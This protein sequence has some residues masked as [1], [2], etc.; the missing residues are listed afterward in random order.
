[1]YS[2][3][4]QKCLPKDIEDVNEKI[5]ADHVE[6]WIGAKYMDSSINEVRACI[7]HLFSSC[8]TEDLVESLTSLHSEN[9]TLVSIPEEVIKYVVSVIHS[10]SNRSTFNQMEVESYIKNKCDAFASD[11]LSK[12]VKRSKSL[13]SWG[14]ER[15]K[16]AAVQFAFEKRYKFVEYT[17]GRPTYQKNFGPATSMLLAAVFRFTWHLETCSKIAFEAPRMDE[18]ENASVVLLDQFPMLKER[19]QKF[20]N[21]L[22]ADFIDESEYKIMLRSCFYEFSALLDI[23]EKRYSTFNHFEKFIE[24]LVIESLLDKCLYLRFEYS[25]ENIERA[26]NDMATYGYGKNQNVIDLEVDRLPNFLMLNIFAK[27]TLT[28]PFQRGF[29][30]LALIWSE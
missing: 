22:N 30:S 10:W 17:P 24:D 27:G 19:L 20:R 8:S 6:A 3:L 23:V 18:L 21:V 16:F 14:N 11:I 9:G 26:F 4:K 29:E 2:F 1:M 7:A 15:L 13:V 12:S 5:L 28:G 25:P